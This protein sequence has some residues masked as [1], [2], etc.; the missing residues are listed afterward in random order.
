MK[1]TC[2]FAVFAVLLAAVRPAHAV[3]DELDDLLYGEPTSAQQPNE[4][5]ATQPESPSHM[6]PIGSDLFERDTASYS[7]QSRWRPAVGTTPSRVSVNKTPAR[8]A[9][10]SANS[11]TSEALPPNPVPEPSAVILGGLALLYFLVFGRRRRLA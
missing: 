6:N 7:D 3:A 5:I 4:P 9:N 8:A 2:L 10:P 1:S 11:K